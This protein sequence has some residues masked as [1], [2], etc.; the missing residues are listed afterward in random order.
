MEDEGP[1]PLSYEESAGESGINSGLEEDAR[2]MSG[3]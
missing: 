1:S 3:V 2:E